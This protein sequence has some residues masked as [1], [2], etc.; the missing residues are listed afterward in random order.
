MAKT[1][2][3]NWF[4]EAFGDEGT[5]FGLA[6]KQRCH[7]EQTPYQKLEVYETETFGNLL[8]LDGCIMLTS[9]DNFL[10][11]EMLTHPAM[12]THPNPSKV[13]VV[14][15]GDCGTLK[16]VLKHPNVKSA[17]QVEIDERVT[18]VSKIYFPELCTSN[19]DP[20]ASFFYE[21][22]AAW[23]ANQKDESIDLL[24][25]DSTDPI[26]PAA[27]LF[28]PAFLAQA[29]RVLRREGMI[30]QQ[31]ESPI[32]HATT[33]IADL[34]QQLLQAGF[35]SPAQICFP[36]PSYPS[37]WWSA[38]M[39]SKSKTPS[40]PRYD[41]IESK[42]WPTHYYNRAIHDAALAKP[43]FMKKPTTTE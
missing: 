21:D 27:Q 38:T 36:Q 3:T 37:G 42:S 25:I 4:D 31:S 24:I 13:V 16:E 2:F 34:E 23:I 43:E 5:R 7:E 28:G 17:A 35:H 18:A 12:F 40:K 10:Y 26:G 39:A 11:H 32:L 20:R 15:G 8:V 41:D 29:F 1:S 22:A 30:V 6:I 9:R 14:G 19:D 33:L